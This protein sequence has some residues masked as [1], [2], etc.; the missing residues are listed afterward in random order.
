V[1]MKAS[2]LV[3]LVLFV[4]CASAYLVK[5]TIVTTD[6][7]TTVARFCISISKK[8]EEGKGGVFLNQT[9]KEYNAGRAYWVLFTDD[10]YDSVFLNNSVS[11]LEKRLINGGVQARA[12]EKELSQ[13]WKP[14]DYI[15]P[16]IWYMVLLNCPTESTKKTEKLDVSYTIHFLD[17]DGGE[18]GYDE[19]G[20]LALNVVYLIFFAILGAFHGVAVFFLFNKGVAH[21][22]VYILAGVIACIVLS[23][24]FVT[25]HWGVYS[26]NGVGANGCRVFGQLLMGI[27]NIVFAVLLIA[28]ASG[29]AITYH[30]LPRKVVILSIAAVYFVVYLI[31][32]IVINATGQT[33]ASTQFVYAK[34]ALLAFVIIYILVCWIG[35]WSYFAYCL[36]T[37][38]REEAQFDKRLF[39][40][41]FGIG[42]TVWFLLPALFNF[43]SMGI[44]EWFR[45]RV[46][47]A[48]QLTVSFI[49]VTALVVLLWPS[50]VE[51]YFRISSRND[52]STSDALPAPVAAPEGAAA[53]TV[54]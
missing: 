41:I 48:F 12:V 42:A 5:D 16:H 21:P 2:V 28:I 39:Y 33:A 54:A 11:C 8:G 45:P 36:Y 37:T 25:I 14:H 23:L 40:L 19:R 3:A 50:R 53:E 46:V 24:F 7:Y 47:D 34:G 15:R 29:W 44:A 22:I 27:A 30:D 17:Q 4:A 31:L 10:Q 35:V 18:V 20:L 26:S 9:A 49:G 43:I 6:E 38:W 32:F 51:K 13:P 1:K 52:F